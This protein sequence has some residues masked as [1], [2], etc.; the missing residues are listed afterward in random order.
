LCSAK[1]VQDVDL[2]EDARVEFC[3]GAC[4]AKELFSRDPRIKGKATCSV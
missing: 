2:V 4:P 1:A 3:S